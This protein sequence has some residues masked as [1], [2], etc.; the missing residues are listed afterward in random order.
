M[1][2]FKAF[3][4][5]YLFSVEMQIFCGSKNRGAYKQIRLPEFHWPLS[6]KHLRSSLTHTHAL[7]TRATY[8]LFIHL[9]ARLERG[10]FFPLLLFCACALI[11]SSFHN[12]DCCGS[13]NQT[14]V[15]TRPVSWNELKLDCR[16]YSQQLP[17][18]PPSHTST[19]TL[20][21]TAR[22]TLHLYPALHS[23]PSRTFV[24]DI[25]ARLV[26]NGVKNPDANIN[27]IIL[28]SN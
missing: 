18:L 25:N 4:F 7:T 23:L 19:L 12:S 20:L 9:K 22:P 3:D 13:H 6:A 5:H 24:S 8:G 2:D 16:S 17:I 27:M 15:G 26:A 21:F 10:C 28:F 1:V 11:G 14:V